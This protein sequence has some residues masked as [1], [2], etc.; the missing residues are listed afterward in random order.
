[1]SKTKT[2]QQDLAIQ[3]GSTPGM[4]SH[5]KKGRYKTT[6]IGLAIA[7]AKITGKAPYDFLNDKIR[8]LAV[9]INPSLRRVR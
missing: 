7:V 9:K 2:T 1:M 3:E 4:L 8:D 6:N 5:L